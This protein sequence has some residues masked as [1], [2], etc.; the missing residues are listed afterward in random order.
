MASK[1]FNVSMDD[2]ISQ[3]R[4]K[5]PFSFINRKKEDDMDDEVPAGVNSDSVY[6]IKQPKTFW[7]KFVENFTGVDEEDF[8]E[9]EK[10]EVLVSKESEQEFEQEY[11]EIKQDEKKGIFGWISN[12]FSTK[13]NETYEDLDQEEKIEHSNKSDDEVKVAD[14]NN[15]EKVSKSK[16]GFFKNFLAFFGSG[17]EEVEQEV[18]DSALNEINTAASANIDEIK[19]DL[20]DVAIIATA[21][22]KKLPKDQFE[23]FKNSSDFDKFKKILK[24]H[25]IIK[26]K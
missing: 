19:Q 11:D 22:F 2:Y 12:I 13:V 6:I 8:Q 3:R 15:V 9:K 7:Q 1:D 18:V 23:L 17:K 25:N 26:E 10:E 21:T 14:N 24:K 5:K 20:K 16:K 4:D